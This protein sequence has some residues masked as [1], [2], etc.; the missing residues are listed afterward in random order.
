MSCVICLAICGALAA[1]SGRLLCLS[2]GLRIVP[3]QGG[4]CIDERGICLDHHSCFSPRGRR[5]AMARRDGER[6]VLRGMSRGGWTR[7]G[8][9]TGA[10]QAGRRTHE[11]WARRASLCSG[12]RALAGGRRASRAYLQK[13]ERRTRDRPLSNLQRAE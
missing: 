13:P 11:R 10:R 5:R 4:I 9:E 2:R 8:V 12:A 7:V 1:S 6:P 3:A